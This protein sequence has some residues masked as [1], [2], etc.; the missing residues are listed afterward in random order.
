M[1][2][3]D[4]FSLLFFG[5][6]S[7]SIRVL[8]Y[9]L[10]RKLC[11]VQVVTKTHSPLDKFSHAHRLAKHHWPHDLES[12]DPKAFNIGLVA[13]F[14]HLIDVETVDRFEYGLFNV[15][16]SLLPKYRGSTPIQAAVFNQDKVTG[17]TIM[18]IPPVAKFDIGDI[19]LQEKLGIKEGE[20]AYELRDRLADLGAQLTEKLLTDFDYQ[21]SKAL[22]QNSKDRSYAKKL[23][24]QQGQLDFRSETSNLIT[25]KVRAYTE[26]IDL[27]MLLVGELKVKLDCMQ[28]PRE[29]QENFDLNRLVSDYI[30]EREK[31]SRS[32][33]D[34]ED[35]DDSYDS[36]EIRN[37][38]NLE[39]PAGTIFFHKI[40]RLLCIKCSDDKWLAFAYAT[41]EGKPNM[42]AADFYNGYLS[43]L[44]PLD[45]RTET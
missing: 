11:P 10:N 35:S 20:Y 28:D 15:H 40:R 9:I 14:G 6:D 17:C 2:A 41:P 30:L 31:T 36:S 19:I 32:Y 18:R 8:Q 37:N 44:D 1:P 39:I 43:R 26:F 22:P 34:R 29:V 33:E 25:R 21:L 45:R 42:S 16:P 3:K 4:H 12:I 38:R 23:T 27:Y 5:S 7:F 24:P 13:S